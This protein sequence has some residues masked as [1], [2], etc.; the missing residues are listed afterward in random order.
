MRPPLPDASN[1][2]ALLGTIQDMMD[3]IQHVHGGMLGYSVFVPTMSFIQTLENGC[4]GCTWMEESIKVLKRGM[5]LTYQREILSLHLF[6]AGIESDGVSYENI[7]T[8]HTPARFTMI[9]HTHFLT[10]RLFSCS[11]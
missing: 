4:E 9:H 8:M 5:R 1:R 3:Y 10:H 7:I 2:R 11:S 6:E